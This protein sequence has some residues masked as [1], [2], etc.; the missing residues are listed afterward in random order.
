MELWGPYKW[1]KI[2][3]SPWGF[4][5]PIYLKLVLGPTLQEVPEI[6]Q[7]WKVCCGNSQVA[8]TNPTVDLFEI[9]ER[10]TIYAKPY[11]NAQCTG[12]VT[13]YFQKNY[14]NVGKYRPYIEHLGYAQLLSCEKEFMI[15]YVFFLI[16]TSYPS[17][18]PRWNWHYYGQKLMALKEFVISGKCHKYFKVF[19]G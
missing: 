10:A 17:I 2:H 9:L 3:G 16:W 1:P 14:P 8:E 5:N 19:S 6:P 4:I 7:S 11:P 13:I 18:A 15:I 12:I